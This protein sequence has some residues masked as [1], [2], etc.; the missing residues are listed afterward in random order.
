MRLQGFPGAALVAG[1]GLF[2]AMT[3]LL[4]GSRTPGDM[5]SFRLHLAVP[6]ALLFASGAAFT[7]AVAIVIGIALTR[8]R[9]REVEP[10]PEPS[11]LPWWLQALMKVL[12]LLPLL[13]TLVVFSVGWPYVESSLLAWS[14]FVMFGGSDPGAP[15]PE[16]PVISLPWLGW[17]A[18]LVL[19]LAGLATLGVA[20]VLLFAERIARWWDARAGGE[21]AEPLSEAVQEGLDDLATDPDARAAIVRCYRRFERVAA[22]A[23]VVRAPWQTPDEFMR[24]TLRR[25]VLPPRA[26]DRLTRLF[27]LAR[28]SA[29]PLG[30]AE[31]DQARA[32]LE[33]IRA[34]LEREEAT[35]GV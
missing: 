5:P 18:G 35:L 9:R 6:D 22:R 3:A 4:A 32:C 33:D 21:A 8:D 12:P 31:R 23:R 34:E 28:F 29:H 26:V 27:E 25:L 1:A 11:K 17:L 30:T 2:L 15:R 13:A 24:E 16:I 19:L 7:L 14:R 10:V 20:L